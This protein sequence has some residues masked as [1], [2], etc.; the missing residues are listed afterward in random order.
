[1]PPP[2]M[3]APSTPAWRTGREAAAWWR[4]F[5]FSCWPARKVPTRARAAGER[6]NQAGEGLRLLRQRLLARQRRALLQQV[7]H[8]QRRRLVAR[9]LARLDPCRIER[10][11]VGGEA[12]ALARPRCLPV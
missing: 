9:G 4:I 1:M 7:H 12:A 6:A 3:P 11:F 2:M 5:F 10:G 8:R